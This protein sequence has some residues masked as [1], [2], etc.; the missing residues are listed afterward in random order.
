[1]LL[2]E[3]TFCVPVLTGSY[4]FQR[5][6]FQSGQDPFRFKPPVQIEAEREGT[7]TGVKEGQTRWES[8]RQIKP[9]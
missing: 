7:T 1:M 8:E 9:R 4:E 3:H 6:A 2:N 5:D